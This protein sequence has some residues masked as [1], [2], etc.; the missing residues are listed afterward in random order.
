MSGPNGETLIVIPGAPRG[1]VHVQ[2]PTCGLIGWHDDDEPMVC[3]DD[4]TLAIALPGDPDLDDFL[5]ARIERD[6]P[7]G[8]PLTAKGDER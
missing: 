6:D 5:I 7:A 4:G 8:Y 2:C 1:A 3:P